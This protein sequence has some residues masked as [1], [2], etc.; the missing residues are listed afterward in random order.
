MMLLLLL[1][2]PVML[3]TVALCVS[4]VLWMIFRQVG[5]ARR[6]TVNCHADRLWYYIVMKD[7]TAGIVGGAAGPLHL[8]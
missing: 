1:L 8:Y 2:L 4:M 5:G 3:M 7:D 6:L